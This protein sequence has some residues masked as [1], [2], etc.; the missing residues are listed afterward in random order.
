[1]MGG[2]PG[3]ETLLFPFMTPEPK[4]L[5]NLVREK[6]PHIDVVYYQLSRPPVGGGSKQIGGIPHAQEVIPE[7]MARLIYTELKQVSLS[8]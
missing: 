4:H 2:G 6:F 5:T 7:G 3:K 8:S 1:M